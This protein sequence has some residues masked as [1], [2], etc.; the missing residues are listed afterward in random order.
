MLLHRARIG[1]F[2]GIS[3][4]A[5]DAARPAPEQVLLSKAPHVV[6]QARRLLDVRAGIVRR[7]QIVLVDD[8]K[9]TAIGPRKAIKVPTGVKLIDL[10]DAFALPGL[11]D[12]HTHLA[13]KPA[14]S[15][16]RSSN[17]VI[18]ADAARATLLAGF[19]TVRNLGSTGR[20]DLLL[21]DAIR[22]GRVPGPRM[23]AAGAGIGI[24]GGTCDRVFGGEAVASLPADLA[25][26]VER[27]FTEG[28][29]VIK[30]CAGGGVISSDPG[31]AELAIEQLGA[32]VA[33]AHRLGRKV[34][35]HA[36]GAD[37]IA[38]AVAAGVDSIEHGTFIDEASARKMRE[39][40]IYLVPTLYRM[41]WIIEQ[42]A[43][44]P[45]SSR[46][47]DIARARAAAHDHV[48]RA[49]QAGVPIALGTDSSVYPD[50]LN[51]REI[52]VLVRLGLSPL[53][54]IRAATI[55]AAQLLGLESEVGALE[56]GKRADL[57]AVQG[58]PLR[59]VRA[60]EQV[61]FVMKDGE[62]VK[63]SK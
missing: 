43:T 49:I 26:L 27:L 30:V 1:L 51:A 50:G 60:V 11:I 24:R 4:I 38:N 14:D 29:D 13:W 33:A 19:T 28:A 3:L 2:M 46:T 53:E 57:V 61:D 63:S 55:H 17:E 9:I 54:A 20:T 7:D 35:A 44:K 48:R 56:P 8:G 58:D 59:D 32:V 31:T 15:S 41:D 6:I 37:A 10:G 23:V 12:A 34:A 21:R 42:G 18:G 22:E 16:Q 45:P 47:D 39:R 40:R 62:V 52:A 36:Q 25:R 5:A